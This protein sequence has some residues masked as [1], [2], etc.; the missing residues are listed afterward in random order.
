MKNTQINFKN[1][2]HMRSFIYSLFGL[3]WIG[4]A[5]LEMHFKNDAGFYGCL[6]I[7][8]IWFAVSYLKKDND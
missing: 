5:L 3:V 1:S 6:T 4:L 8:N 7:A 2:T